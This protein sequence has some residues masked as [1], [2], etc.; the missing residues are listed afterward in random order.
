MFFKFLVFLRNACALFFRMYAT[1]NIGLVAYRVATAAE[2]PAQQ[3]V[4][5]CRLFA[6]DFRGWLTLEFERK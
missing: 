6:L 2:K 4:F 5:V 3:I 1:V